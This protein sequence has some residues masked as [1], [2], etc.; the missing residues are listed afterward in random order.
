MLHPN[1]PL[2]R[3][4]PPTETFQWNS[5]AV[6]SIPS[7]LNGGIL[8][9]GRLIPVLTRYLQRWWS[10]QR[11]LRKY[12]KHRLNGGILI[13]GTL[14]GG[15]LKILIFRH[16]NQFASKVDAWQVLNGG[17]LIGGILI[18]GI[19]IGGIL[20]YSFFRV[21]NQFVLKW[22]AWFWQVLNGGILIGGILIGGILKILIFPPSK[23]ICVKIRWLALKST[24]RRNRALIGGFAVATCSLRS[25]AYAKV[26]E[27]LMK[28]LGS[29]GVPF[30]RRRFRWRFVCSTKTTKKWLERVKLEIPV[31]D[32]TDSAIG[33]EKERKTKKKP[34]E[35][36]AAMETAPPNEWG[37]RWR[38]RTE[39]DEMRRN[40]NRRPPRSHFSLFVVCLWCWNRLSLGLESLDYCL[41]IFPR[42]KLS[43]FGRRTNDI[44]S[45]DGR[46]KWIHF[47]GH[48]VLLCSM[49][50]GWLGALAIASPSWSKFSTLAFT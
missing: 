42:L 36:V 22:D 15:I 47:L 26:E 44:S 43:S 46:V 30:R 4:S 14:I 1:G 5:F 10:L 17:I 35:R 39:I 13:G 40:T 29:A 11:V 34:S 37:T 31:W 49:W 45:I 50:S 41:S 6:N 18:G 25:L 24:T 28:R 38:V 8:I 7:W 27:W 33:G 48:W 16:S 2:P 32:G 19:L 21:S 3:S 9:C 23:S 20:K 12:F